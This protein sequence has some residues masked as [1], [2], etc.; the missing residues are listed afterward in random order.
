MGTMPGSDAQSLTMDRNRRQIAP[1]PETLNRDVAYPCSAV[2]VVKKQRAKNPGAHNNTELV[3]DT[4]RL[5]VP[6]RYFEIML[7]VPSEDA[8]SF[9]AKII[10]KKGIGQKIAPIITQWNTFLFLVAAILP[11]AITITISIRN[12]ATRIQ[13]IASARYLT[14]S[15]VSV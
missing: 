14:T 11:V 1:E 12:S 15:W 5:T 9:G 7:P 4:R 2:V 6:V 3:F 8:G 10:M 13:S